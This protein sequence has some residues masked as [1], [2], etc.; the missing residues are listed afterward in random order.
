MLAGEPGQGG[1][2]LVEA[3]LPALMPD[4]V[5]GGEHGLVAGAPQAAAQ[6][7]QKDRRALGGP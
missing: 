5:E 1:E 6:L 3:E 4:E 2:L 7:L